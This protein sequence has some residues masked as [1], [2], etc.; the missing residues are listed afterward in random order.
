MSDLQKY[1][2]S[3]RKRKHFPDEMYYNI[4]QNGQ[5]TKKTA[6]ADSEKCN[7]FNDFFSDV[8]T[9]DSKISE[10]SVY[11]KPRLNYLRISEEEI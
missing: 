1:L 8:F 4:V 2:K 3:L 10:P 6:T 9:K 5:E 11:P 7:L